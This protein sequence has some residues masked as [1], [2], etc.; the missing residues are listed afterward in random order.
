MF[1]DGVWIFYLEAFLALAVG[2]FIVWWTLPKKKHP[3][4][5]LLGSNVKDG[6]TPGDAGPERPRDGESRRD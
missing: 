5:A 2:L 1:D 4:D 3:D 6:T